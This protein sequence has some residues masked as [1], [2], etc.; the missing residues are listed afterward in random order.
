MPLLLMPL[1]AGAAAVVNVVAKY[2][3]CFEIVDDFAHYGLSSREKKA[4]N[5][6]IKCSF[7]IFHFSHDVKYEMNAVCKH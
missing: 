3:S 6:N 7:H 4:A 2:E 1:A 5:Y